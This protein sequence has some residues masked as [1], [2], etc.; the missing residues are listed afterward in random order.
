MLTL[1]SVATALTLYSSS[2]ITA[3]CQNAL[4]LYLT[5]ISAITTCAQDSNGK[6]VTTVSHGLPTTTMNTVFVYAYTYKT[7]GSPGYA[8]NN[9][10]MEK[11]TTKVYLKMTFDPNEF[12]TNQGC[13]DL[14]KDANY[15]SRQC[16]IRLDYASQEQGA[17]LREFHYKLTL[18]IPLTVGV[19]FVLSAIPLKVYGCDCIVDA[20]L[21]YETKVFKGTDCV[22]QIFTGHTLV[23]GDY[24]CL[25]LKGTDPI[26]KLAT[27]DLANLTAVYKN[28]MGAYNYLDVTGVSTSK[29]STDNTCIKGQIYVITPIIQVGTLQYNMIVTLKDVRRLSSDGRLLGDLPKGLEGKF[30]QEFTVVESFGS[31]IMASFA[32]L[33]ALLFIAL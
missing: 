17:V 19:E 24:L 2:C 13:T 29:C 32:V 6:I 7:A 31:S 23:Y 20:T 15:Q 22:T 18:R 10:A 33:L 26:S 11:D 1:L 28:S 3:P 12:K 30:D 5:G 21:T 8:I 25:F 16:G 4:M 27:F 9:F 14:G